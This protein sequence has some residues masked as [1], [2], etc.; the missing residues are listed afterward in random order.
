[1]VPNCNTTS[2]KPYSIRITKYLC[3]GIPYERTTVNYCKTVLRRNQPTILNVSVNVPE[4]LN[5]IWVTVKLYYKFRTFQPFLIDME[6]EGCEYIKNRP[7]IPLTDYI[8]EIFQKSVPDLSSP[9]P[10]GNKTYK[11]ETEFKEEYAPKS[12]PAVGWLCGETLAYWCPNQ[13]RIK[14]RLDQL[15]ELRCCGGS[16]V[17][18]EMEPFATQPQQGHNWPTSARSVGWSMSSLPKGYSH[19]CCRGGVYSCSHGRSWVSG[20]KAPAPVAPYRLTS[21]CRRRAGACRVPICCGNM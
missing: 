21:V 14:V 5:Y 3:V 15:G 16:S 13:S 1:M 19:K 8:Y 20:G 7:V 18:Q 11:I 2:V 9:C 12:V 6:Q 4:V 17:F 10:H